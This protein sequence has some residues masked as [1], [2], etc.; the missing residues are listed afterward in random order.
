MDKIYNGKFDFLVY[1][2]SSL[3]YMQI[4]SAVHITVQTV[5]TGKADLSSICWN[6]FVFFSCNQHQYNTEQKYTYLRDF[7]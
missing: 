1:M 6:S 3:M 4:K 2:H 5:K 7:I